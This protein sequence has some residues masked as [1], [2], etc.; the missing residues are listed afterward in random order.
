MGWI[1]VWL[2]SPCI[3]EEER[4]SVVH[5]L[6]HSP[7]LLDRYRWL[8]ANQS[9][10]GEDPEWKEDGSFQWYT[11]QWTTGTPSGKSYGIPG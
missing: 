8:W 2:E 11:F 4:R 6:S 10:I 1:T 9:W 3:T 7:A 5:A